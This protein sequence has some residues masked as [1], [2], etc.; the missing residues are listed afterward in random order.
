[1]SVRVQMPPLLRTLTGGAR[2]MTAKGQSV[3]EVMADLSKQHPLIARHV[4]DDEGNIRCSI[5]FLHDG[6]LVRAG[7]TIGA[8]AIIGCDLVIGRFAMV[9]MGSVVTRPVPD[10]HLV[11]GSPARAI[12]KLP[13]RAASVTNGSAEGGSMTTK[14]VPVSAAGGRAQAGF[15]P[16][17]CR[18]C[19]STHC[20]ALRVSSVALVRLSF[21]LMCSR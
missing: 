11:V 13:I 7:A 3:A 1:M 12:G 14:S 19:S 21:C 16:A 6:T 4:F 10:F 15:S 5:V 9:G 20:T 8:G 2:Q 17:G 18:P